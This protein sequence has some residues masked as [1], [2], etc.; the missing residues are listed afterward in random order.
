MSKTKKYGDFEKGIV[1]EMHLNSLKEGGNHSLI[2][3]HKKFLL[4]VYKFF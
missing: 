3:Q 4:L 1:K 2:S